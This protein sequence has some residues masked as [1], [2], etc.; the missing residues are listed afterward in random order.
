MISCKQDDLSKTTQ[1]QVNKNL[2]T[3]L[4]TTKVSGAILIYDEQKDFYITNDSVIANEGQLPASTFKIANSLI[5]LE[6]GVMAND[7]IIIP[8]DGTD[9]YLDSWEEDMTFRE[10]FHRSCV[11]CYQDIAREIGV[12]R[13][14]HWTDQL[15]YGHLSIDSNSIDNFWLRGSSLISPL[16]QI[17]FLR[18]LHTESL[19][20][21]R[22][23]Y[24]I[25]KKMMIVR[26]DHNRILRAKTGW[27]VN[28]NENNGW[29]VGYIE[30]AD[31]VI[32]FAI[33]IEPDDGYDMQ[34]FS[35]DRIKI[36]EQALKRLGYQH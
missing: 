10:A 9:K 14:I 28:G 30:K 35:R 7:S 3:I 36:A 15:Q 13:M 24:S 2:Q 12:K 8:W 17:D 11:P 23:T 1:W 34:H 26:E 5:A 22:R 33:N 19:P 21:S 18:G 25:F 20:L 31:N 29:Y 32:C 6:T 4:D 27:S 16:E